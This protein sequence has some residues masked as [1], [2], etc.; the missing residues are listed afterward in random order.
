M[1]K[2][3]S[4]FISGFVASIASPAFAST[5][6]GATGYC[7]YTFKFLSKNEISINY[8]C[9]DNGHG[10]VTQPFRTY[11]YPNG[12]VLY[13]TEPTNSLASM[14]VGFPKNGTPYFQVSGGVDRYNLTCKQ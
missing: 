14:T 10:G 12:D 9:M 4:L 1:K 5:C 7:Q 13:V 6:V 11:Q 2:L 3:V 8:S